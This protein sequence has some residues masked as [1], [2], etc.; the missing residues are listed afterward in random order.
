MTQ[1]GVVAQRQSI[2]L[3]LKNILGSRVRT[4]AAPFFFLYFLTC[5]GGGMGMKVWRIRSGASA[6]CQALDMDM[7][8]FKSIRLQYSDNYLG[9]PCSNHGRP[10]F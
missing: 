3:Q 6:N 9:V 8:L 2:R 7:Q 10:S 4:T 1:S 5:P